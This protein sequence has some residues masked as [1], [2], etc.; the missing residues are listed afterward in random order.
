[1]SKTKIV[2][3]YRGCII[4]P[5]EMAGYRHAPLYSW[6]HPDWMDCSSEPGDDG[7]DCIWCGDGKTIEECKEQIDEYYINER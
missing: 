7:W 5:H 4:E 6:F 2:E 1:M 3:K